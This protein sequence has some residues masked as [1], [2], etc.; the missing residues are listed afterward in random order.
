MALQ[1]TF[2]ME[3]VHLDDFYVI[4]ICHGLLPT[5]IQAIMWNDTQGENGKGEMTGR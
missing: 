1:V 3:V 5:L 4:K 2:Q